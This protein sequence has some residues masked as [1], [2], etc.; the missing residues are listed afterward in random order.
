MKIVDFTHQLVSALVVGLLALCCSSISLG[1]SPVLDRVVESG[2]L[3]VAMSADQPPFSLR[4]REQ[5]LI[6]YDVDLATA[7]A[8]VMKVELEIVETPFANL[9]DTLLNNR[10]DMVIS[11][12][13]ITPERTQ[14]VSFIGPY[15]L[16]GKSILTTSRIESVVDDVAQFNDPN[17]RMV[18]LSSSTSEMFAE[19]NFPDADYHAIASYDE[20]VQMLVTGRIDAMI[21]DIPILKLT[22][23]RYPEASLS[24]L[25]PPLSVESLGIA[26][27]PN[28]YQFESLV[29]NYLFSFETN[30]MTLNW[31][32]KWFEDISWIAQ[33]PQQ[34]N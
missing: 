15:V 13:T 1:A 21:A 8:E 32:R 19:S 12:M 2:V 23:M 16:S 24:L 10:A 14:S 17:I 6:G 18:A 30:G 3:R 26:I 5:K 25:E 31:Y 9:L 28:D 29:R 7:L 33:L 34:L 4:N 22:M 20:G 11:G 27:R